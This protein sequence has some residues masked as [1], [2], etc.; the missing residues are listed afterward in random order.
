MPTENNVTP[1]EESLR[2]VNLKSRIYNDTQRFGGN[3]EK[4]IQRDGEKCVKCG[5]S[6]SDHRD[7]Y[8]KDITVDHIDNNG[9]YKPADKRNNSLDNLQTLCIRCHV[10]KDNRT[11]KISDLDAIN[12]RHVR[13]SISSYRLGKMY[14]VDPSYIYDIWDGRAKRLE[15]FQLEEESKQ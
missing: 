1:V 8:G 10:K 7:K 12:I 5:L 3:R 15:N 2:M 14:K 11:N 6:R 13:G 9:I 4:A